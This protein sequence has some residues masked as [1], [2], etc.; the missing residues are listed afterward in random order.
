MALDHPLQI[1]DVSAGTGLLLAPM[2]DVSEPPFRLVCRQLG[3]DMV[4][5]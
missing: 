4:Y 3:A 1:G 2:E 5:T